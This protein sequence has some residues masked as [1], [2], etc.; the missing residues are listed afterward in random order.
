MNIRKERSHRCGHTNIDFRTKNDVDN[1]K[2]FMPW[3][4]K[5]EFGT[6]GNNFYSLSFNEKKKLMKVTENINTI[7]NSHDEFP[8]PKY[9][10]TAQFYQSNNMQIKKKAMTCDERIAQLDESFK[11][12]NKFTGDS[13]MI[14]DL[15]KQRKQRKDLEREK[16]KKIK[17]MISDDDDTRKKKSKL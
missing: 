15:T 8:D 16:L 12:K 11:G 2:T 1:I 7:K 17:N 6:M 5:K 10:K 14:A 4:S 3:K 13:M 9:Y